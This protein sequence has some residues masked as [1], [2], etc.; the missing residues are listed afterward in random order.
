MLSIPA[1]S[2]SSQ[3]D[4]NAWLCCVPYIAAEMTLSY[5]L[6]RR[7]SALRL[8]PFRQYCLF[9]FLKLIRFEYFF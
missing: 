8:L 4:G 2:G 9:V 1:T 6:L 7:R 5:E 3:E